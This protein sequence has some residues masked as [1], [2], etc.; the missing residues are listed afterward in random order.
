MEV[1]DYQ[2]DYQDAYYQLQ[3]EVAEQLPTDLD[4]EAFLD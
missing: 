2:Q 1:Q 3:D 4:E